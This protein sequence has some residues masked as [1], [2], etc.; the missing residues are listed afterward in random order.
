MVMAMALGAG[1]APTGVSFVLDGKGG[2]IVPVT[3]G[4]LHD[5]HFLLDTGSTRSVVSE[6]VAEQLALR[7]AAR[8][9]VVTLA[10]ASMAVVVALPATCLATR[11]VDDALAI[12]APKKALAFGSRQLDG[13]LGGDI[14][15]SDL[16]IDYQRRRFAWDNGTAAQR[17]DDRLPLS[18]EDGRAIVTARQPGGRSLRLV[19]DSG[20]D[21]VV[22]FD[23]ELVRSLSAGSTLTRFALQTLGGARRAEAVAIPQ[24][25]VGAATWKDEI[26]AIV[27][28]PAAYPQT[29][30]GILP[31]NRFASVSFRRSESALIVRHR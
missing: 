21:A 14:L 25:R 6:A 15:N 27:P 11:C 9:E 17:N 30:D 29:I 20:A 2:V 3:V 5:L 12:V 7:P 23:G 18:M 16:A 24:L 26:A 10:G 1:T 8:T 28:R 13:I 4:A 22:L 31:L 19:A